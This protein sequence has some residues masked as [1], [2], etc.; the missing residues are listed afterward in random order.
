MLNIS[1]NKQYLSILSSDSYPTSVYD[2][3]V[4]YDLQSNQIVFQTTDSPIGY[5]WSPD[6]SKI[7]IISTK[8]LYETCKSNYNRKYRVS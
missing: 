6:S 3:F 4:L 5:F 1:P 2:R 7:I 8:L